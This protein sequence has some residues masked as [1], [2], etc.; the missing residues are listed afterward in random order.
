MSKPTTYTAKEKTKDAY[1]I[2]NY[3]ISLAEY[4]AVHKHQRGKCAICGQ[5]ESRFKNSF[6]V[7]HCH[8]TGLVRGLLCW[9]CN[10]ALGKFEDSVEKV[11]AAAQYVTTPPMTVV[12][13]ASRYTAPGRIGTKARAAAL[14]KA[15]GLP[16]VKRKRKTAKVKVAKKVVKRRAPVRKK[17]K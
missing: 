5:D 15:N 8:L 13:G 16:P 1:L 17:A 10:R 4:R 6:A 7:D 12:L 9:R 11:C 3:G 2:R 14:R